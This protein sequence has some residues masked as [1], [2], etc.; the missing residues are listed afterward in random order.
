M[1]GYS[2]QL[3]TTQQILQQIQ[4]LKKSRTDGVIV[5]ESEDTSTVPNDTGANVS[6]HRLAAHQAVSP[7]IITTR[8]NAT[9]IF[10]K[11]ADQIYFNPLR[12]NSNNVSRGDT[13]LCPISNYSPNTCE[14]PQHRLQ[15]LRDE[16]TDFSYELQLLKQNPHNVNL[17]TTQ[18]DSIT[19]DVERELIAV[20][21][22]LAALQS[23]NHTVQARD[24]EKVLDNLAAA[25]AAQKPLQDTVPDAVSN[26]P[27]PH[28]TGSTAADID[29]RLSRLQQQLGSTALRASSS[30]VDGAQFDNVHTAVQYAV[31]KLSLLDASRVIAVKQQCKLASVDLQVLEQQHKAYNK[32]AATL[33]PQQHAH[34]E[35]TYKILSQ[36]EPLCTSIPH[37]IH[38]LHQLRG[39]HHSTSGV[40]RRVQTL[41]SSIQQL[42]Q[43][44]HTDIQAVN[45]L[46]QSLADTVANMQINFQQINERITQ[47]QT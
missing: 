44:R 31:H 18:L 35:Q 3:S 46:T 8:S 23:V 34:I 29:A 1:H 20:Q 24:A 42:D 27:V 9:V 16:L 45:Q 14:L 30:H 17:R 2:A 5:Y 19:S 15:R 32:Q 37:L 7:D 22:Q 47:L 36:Y 41:E 10:E 39:L 4:T 13:P 26:V 28:H 38:H 25:T 43:Q 21:E 12:Y 33:T 11:F 40:M 6:V